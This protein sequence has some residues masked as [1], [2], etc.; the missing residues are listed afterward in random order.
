MRPARTRAHPSAALGPSL[1]LL[2]VL[3][4]SPAASAGDGLPGRAPDGQPGLLNEGSQGDY[5]RPFRSQDELS[6]TQ[7]ASLRGVSSEV[8]ILIAGAL[9]SYRGA[10]YLELLGSGSEHD[11][12]ALHAAWDEASVDPL[13]T[14]SGRDREA[15]RAFAR[16][17]VDERFLVRAELLRDFEL[18]VREVDAGLSVLEGA[19][20][21]FVQLGDEELQAIATRVDLAA[22]RL[23]ALRSDLLALR[24]APSGRKAPLGPQAKALLA[25][26]RRE[27]RGEAERELRVLLGGAQEK[28]ELMKRALFSARLDAR[29]Q[30]QL[31][32]RERALGEARMHLEQ[33]R[34][35]LPG[36]LPP[37][38]VPAEILA[39]R[40]HDRLRLAGMR[41]RQGLAVD[42]LNAELAYVVAHAADFQWGWLESRPLYDRFLFL[43]GIRHY[44]HRSMKGRRLT[45]REQEAL[46]V[47]QAPDNP[48]RRPVPRDD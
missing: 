17:A 3:A 34:T 28:V 26:G 40:K 9:E 18:D 31:G 5:L 48:G 7:L 45:P 29:I 10:G 24:S 21:S 36:A 4:A 39:M 23:R 41:A 15:A 6:R 12:A 11:I 38:E 8:R 25:C 44:D 47:V 37:E 42:P 13:A 32:W 33:A 46:I 43:S 22:S 1:G 35:A 27:D 14:L 2:L 19:A 16:M 20:T 30:Q